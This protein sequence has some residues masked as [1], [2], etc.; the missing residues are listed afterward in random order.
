LGYAGT[1]APAPVYN[2]D[3]Y[4][5]WGPTW[6]QPASWWWWQPVGFFAGFNFVPFSTFVVFDNHAF[7]FH[8]HFFHH[9]GKDFKSFP[10]GHGHFFNKN[11]MSVAFHDPAHAF[12][13]QNGKTTFFGA[14]AR[15]TA[16]AAL[17]ARANL[18]KMSGLA[19]G[20]PMMTTPSRLSGPA[21]SG[22]ATRPGVF[23]TSRSVPMFMP[24]MPMRSQMIP[25]GGF[26]PLSP[27]FRS[28]MPGTAPFMPAFR[29]G[30]ASP[31]FRSRA[32]AAPRMALRPSMPM[33]RS[34]V[35]AGFRGGMARG[36]FQGW[37]R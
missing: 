19:S 15:P 23:N 12:F 31:G 16:S 37:H 3:Y 33:A 21:S 17:S 25:P 10:H 7:F 2:P 34:F 11:G 18:Q 24:S 13:H 4:Y 1:P 14:V 27:Q 20:T 30:F 8:H 36:G 35:G 5:D 22:T 32:F 28:G 9:D 29:G 26:R 6:V